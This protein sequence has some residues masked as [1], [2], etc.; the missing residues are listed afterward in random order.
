MNNLVTI[1]L[2]KLDKEQPTGLVIAKDGSLAL[3]AENELKKILDTQDLL[4]K[5]VEHVKQ[6]LGEEMDKRKLIKVKA[7]SIT[8]T[9]RYFGTRYK[10]N[11]DAKDEFIAQVVYNKP[12]VEAIDNYMAINEELPEGIEMR[13]RE[14]K[15]SILRRE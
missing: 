14:Q 6:R 2:S 12:N 15:V 9:K 5:I 11:S 4:E 1:D 13:E 8:I 7:G 3:E 10:L